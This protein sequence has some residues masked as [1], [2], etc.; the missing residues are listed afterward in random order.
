M[1][2]VKANLARVRA[3]ARAEVWVETSTKA[4]TEAAQARAE[5]RQEQ[6]KVREDIL[7][8][9]QVRFP[10][11]NELVQKVLQIISSSG[12]LHFLLIQLAVAANENV[13]RNILQSS[14][15]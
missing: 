12:A 10:E 5:V 13:A 7:K 1:N 15:A 4:W 2:K 9:V 14:A 6:N 3:E 11:L 8:I